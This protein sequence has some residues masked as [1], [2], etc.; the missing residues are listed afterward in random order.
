MHRGTRDGTSGG[1]LGA[2]G[3]DEAGLGD[4]LGITGESVPQG[5]G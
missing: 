5:P 3:A 1:R 4:S 2:S